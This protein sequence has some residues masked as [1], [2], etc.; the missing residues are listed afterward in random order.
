MGRA[1][2]TRYATHLEAAAVHEHRTTG[3]RELP[4]TVESYRARAARTRGRARIHASAHGGRAPRRRT[5]RA[6]RGGR[7]RPGEPSSRFQAAKRGASRSVGRAHSRLVLAARGPDG[8]PALGVRVGGARPGAAAGRPLARRRARARARAASA[9]SPRR[10]R[11]R[12]SRGSSSIPALRFKLD[13]TPEWTD[14]LIATLAARGNVD[15]VDLKGQYQGT[16]VD[17]PPDARALPARRGRRSRA[18]GSRTPR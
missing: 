16:V 15:V 13:P 2:R 5:R 1:A 11:P 17:N 4:L 12:S 3:V 10:A 9:S 14:E 8:L 7:L 18:R 6:R